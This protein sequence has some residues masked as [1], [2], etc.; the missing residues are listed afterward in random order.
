[1]RYDQPSPLPSPL[2][3]DFFD[4]LQRIDPKERDTSA[5]EIVLSAAKELPYG[6]WRSFEKAFYS[7][8][9]RALMGENLLRKHG[10]KS[11]F[12][13]KR[14]TQ[15]FTQCIDAV[16]RIAHG[17]EIC[18]NHARLVNS[19]RPEDGIISFNYDLVVDRALS[20]VGLRRQCKF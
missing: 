17:K 9:L 15:Q 16:L 4:L 13:S 6:T 7:L 11:L 5:I 12:D 1:V 14:L 18:K 20:R 2:D 10:A 19:M 3:S 8:H